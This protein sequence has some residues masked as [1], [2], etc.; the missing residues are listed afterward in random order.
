MSIAA[1]N[2]CNGATFSKTSKFESNLNIVLNNLVKNMNS[3]SNGFNTSAAGQSPNRAYGL[4][5]C[6]EDTTGAECYSCSQEA[7]INIREDCGN[8]IGARAW[9]EKCFIRY[10]NYTFSGNLDILPKTFNNF[11]NATDP[12]VFSKAVKGLFRNLTNEAYE[13]ANRYSSGKTMDSS[14]QKIFGLVQ[15]WRDITSLEDCTACLSVA[16]QQLLLVTAD[17]TQL[18]GVC[19]T[20]SCVARYETYQFFN[21][22]PAAPPPKLQLPSPTSSKKSANKVPIVL[23]IVGGFLV[24]LLLSMFAIRRKLKSLILRKENRHMETG[25]LIT[26]DEQ[27]VFNLEKIRAATNNFHEDNKLGEGGFGP[28]YKG[29]M[30]DGKQIAVKKL[31]AQSQRGKE[32]F[33]NEVKLVAKIQQRN[34]VNILGCCAEGSEP[35]LIY[36]F[37]ANKSLDQILFN[38]QRSKELEWQRRL[39]I[40]RG[41][42]RGLLYLHEDSQPH[43]IHRDIKAS[44]ILLDEKMEPK[45]SDFGLTRLFGQDESLVNTRIAGTFGYMAPEY[46][47][48]GKLST[49]AD[50]YGFGVVLLE[51][52]CGIKNTDVKLLPEYQS[53]L[54]L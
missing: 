13:S 31:S 34:L 40:I 2:I 28:V 4:L 22:S 16:I 39:N 29:T 19:F 36:E 47:M 8:S 17:G 49:K 21:P 14:A 51:I 27:I 23:G 33:L 1:L 50:V 30:P 3:S 38:P 42:A 53:L 20:G 12:A 43:I 25:S 46:A 15:C 44:N 45:I 5:Q 6:R 32:E 9:Y 52:V 18:G 26:Q 7:I 11:W 37:L 48:H 54:E 10:E 41:I 35:L 24:M